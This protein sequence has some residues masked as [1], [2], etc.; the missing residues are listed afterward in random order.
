[1]NFQR[2]HALSRL[3][4]FPSSKGGTGHVLRF[5]CRTKSPLP[6][7]GRGTA[8][9]PTHN[10][11]CWPAVKQSTWLQASERAPSFEKMDYPAPQEIATSSRQDNL[12]RRL[13]PLG[14]VA[15]ALLAS[16]SV[17]FQLLVWLLR[18]DN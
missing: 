17:F 18:H 9:L 3:R 4:T 14:L 6:D 11:P 15:L 1:M 5:P 8:V 2:S 7:N 10:V 16:Y 13:I 12:M